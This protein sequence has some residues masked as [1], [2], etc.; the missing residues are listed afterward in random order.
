M[1]KPNVLHDKDT[2]TVIVMPGEGLKEAARAVESHGPVRT[3][4]TAYGVGLTMSEATAKA[5]G[6]L[7]GRNTRK[8][9]EK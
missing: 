5:A 3:V 2:G 9:K 7:P 8:T 1:A 4:S 6:L